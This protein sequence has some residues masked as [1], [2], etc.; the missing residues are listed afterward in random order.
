MSDADTTYLLSVSSP[1]PESSAVKSTLD[2]IDIGYKVAL[3]EDGIDMSFNIP[4]GME[5]NTNDEEDAKICGFPAV[6]MMCSRW[7]HTM[8][9]NALYAG[10]VTEKLELARHAPLCELEDLLSK[11]AKK[12]RVWLCPE[13]VESTSADFFLV[14]RLKHIRSEDGITFE[15]FPLL[16]K[17]VD[18]DPSLQTPEGSD[19]E[20]DEEIGSQSNVQMYCII[21]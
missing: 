3:V 13:F 18:S 11:N 5:P 20:E 16:A 9:S 8:P 14:S 6:F 17:Y 21:S 12:D 19:K 10:L 15:D 4:A 2:F 1:G 7:A